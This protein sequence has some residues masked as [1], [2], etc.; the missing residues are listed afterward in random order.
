MFNFLPLELVVLKLKPLYLS[1]QVQ[2]SLAEAFIFLTGSIP[3]YCLLVFVLVELI[4]F[5][6]ELFLRLEL[7]LD[8]A[9]FFEQ[10]SIFIG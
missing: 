7:L 3:A 1:C 5:C 2:P 4:Q 8:I 6:N 10:R 9:G